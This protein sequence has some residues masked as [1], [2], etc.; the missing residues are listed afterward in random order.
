MK[1]A[2]KSVGKGLLAGLLFWVVFFAGFYFHAYGPAAIVERLAPNKNFP[3][4][5]EAYGLVKDEGLQ[6]M[7]TAPA[8]E[9]GMILGMLQA[10]GEPHTSFLEP[11]Q[12][13]LENDS[14]AGKFGGIGVRLGSDQEGRVVLYPFP[15]GP[16]AKAGVKEGD[17]LLAVG[18]MQINT[19]TPSDKLQA[20]IRGPIGQKVTITI[21]HAPDFT[22]QKIDITR[23]EIALP[24]TTWHLDPNE[25]RLGVIEINIIAATT[26]DEIQNAVK[27]LQSRGAT[28]YVMDLR[29]NGGGLLNAG[30]DTARLFLKDGVVIQ[31]QYKGKDV[32]T[33]KVD[34]PGPLADIKLAVLVNENTAS[35]AEIIAGSLQGRKRAQLIGT[36][37]Y[38]KDTIQLV[39]EL[40]DKSSL[41]V[42]A[43]HWWV[44]GL[45]FPKD[46]KG[47]RPDI[48]LPDGTTDPMPLV[49]KALFGSN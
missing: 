11:V 19:Q 30:V 26:P 24:S 12:T 43:A 5:F 49:I 41:H 6:P 46:G 36:T 21:G 13:K 48:P 47:L 39:F 28:A 22:A 40:Q 7:P 3:I 33:F 34:K 38:G 27:D 23:A 10:Y 42:T 16:A 31:Q 20:A 45:E 9:Y 25:P 32:E 14:L 29:N 17:R 1:P 2:L 37:T 18:D 8:E 4:L 15:D 44:P 35:A